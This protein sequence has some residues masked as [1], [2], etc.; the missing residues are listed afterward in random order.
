MQ[1]R[2][3]VRRPAGLPPS[4]RSRPMA[5]P[6]RVARHNWR[7]S[8][9]RNTSTICPGSVASGSLSLRAIQEP[10]PAAHLAHGAARDGACFGRAGSEQVPHRARLGLKRLCPL[11]DG[12]ERGYHIVREHPLAVEAT[13]S[14]GAAVVRHQ[15]ERVRWRETLVN[16][17]DVADV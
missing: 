5:P 4:S 13:P 8:S 6:N 11:A 15:L 16:G 12:G 14:C 17:E 9:S 3:L 1:M 2:M 10:H 7:N